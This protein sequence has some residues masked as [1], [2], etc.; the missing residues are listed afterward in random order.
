MDK[1]SD[2]SETNSL[3]SCA[4]VPESEI[5][6]LGKRKG[7]NDGAPPGKKLRGVR[8][9]TCDTW[10]AEYDKEFS[11][12]IWLQYDRCRDGRAVVECIKRKVCVRFAEKICSSKIFSES[13][14]VGSRNLKT[15]AFKDHPASDMHQRAMA[16]FQK[17]KAGGDPLRC[18]PIAQ[19]LTRMDDATASR[20]GSK[21]EITYVLCKEGMAFAK[22]ESL[23]QL[24]E[25][26]GVDLGTDHKNQ[27]AASRSVI[28]PDSR[29]S[30][31][32]V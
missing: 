18:A 17:E 21:F 26:H 25:K 27:K 30:R 9:V 24:E 7:V 29:C 16:L 22:M 14:I 8:V 5:A 31:S 15:S 23:C 3:Y 20:T 11:T 19:G 13:F 6:S 10:I 1:V 32:Y 28:T 2:R 12:S 4:H